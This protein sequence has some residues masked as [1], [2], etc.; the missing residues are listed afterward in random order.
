MPRTEITV[1]VS[2]GNIDYDGA[3]LTQQ[4]ADPV[5]FN[6]STM[7]GG[8]RVIVQNT[9]VA[10]HN[11]TVKSAPD[12]LQRTKEAGPVSIAAG[13]FHIFGPFQPP[14]WRQE[15]DGKLYMDGDDATLMVSVIR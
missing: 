11:F 9:D 13:A 10:A 3:V 7:Q 15:S 5:N 4:A 14:G 8:E 2:P 1:Q 12:V 6:Q